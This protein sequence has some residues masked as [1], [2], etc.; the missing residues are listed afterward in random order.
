MIYDAGYGEDVKL[1]SGARVRFRF[2][3]PAD[4]AKLAEGFARL[5]QGPRYRRFFFEKKSLTPEELRLLTER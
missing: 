1:E 4:R 5:S 2:V 3:R